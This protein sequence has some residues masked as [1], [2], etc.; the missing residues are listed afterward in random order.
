MLAVWNRPGHRDLGVV[1]SIPAH[2]Q[3]E[4]G[5][6]GDVLTRQGERDERRGRV[7]E[8]HATPIHLYEGRETETRERVDYNSY[9]IWHM[10]RTIKVDRVSSDRY[11]NTYIRYHLSTL[12]NV[13][14][15]IALL[16]TV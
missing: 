15:Q 14:Y 11:Y 10:L 16:S 7:G 8:G 3:A 13:L 5:L 9:L 2:T 12:S 4:R 1:V 6:Q